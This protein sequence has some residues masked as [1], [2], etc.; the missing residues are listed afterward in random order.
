MQF[1][2]LKRREFITLLAGTAVAWPLA[3][4]AQQAR[5][6]PTIGFLGATNPSI[7]SQ[8]VAAFVFGSANSVGSTVVTWPLSIAGQGAAMS[9]TQKTPPSS[10]GSRSMSLS[11]RQPRQPW[12]QSKQQRSSRSCSQWCRTRSGLAWSRVWLGRAATLVWRTRHLILPAR[13]SNSCVRPSPISIGWR[14]WPMSAIP[15]LY[16]KWARPRQRPASSAL[17]SLHPKS[18]ERRTLH[19]RQGA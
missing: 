15:P 9:A 4:R 19:L 2:Q 16:W 10:S 7:D 8:R 1:D 3:A 11:R 12:Q 13:N 14:S 18:G 6:L 5:K 17:R